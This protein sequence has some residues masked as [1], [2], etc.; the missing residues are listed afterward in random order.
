MN[1]IL[2]TLYE[3]LNREQRRKKILI[4]N[5]TKEKIKN[6]GIEKYFAL[7]ICANE[8][9]YNKV[10]YNLKNE[11]SHKYFD[12]ITIFN[13][14]EYKEFINNMKFDLSIMNPP[15]GNPKQ[16]IPAYIHN[17]IYNTISNK[18][19]T[20]CIMPCNKFQT[21]HEKNED[22]KTTQNNTKQFIL[23]PAEKANELMSIGTP[24][25]L[26]IYVSFG[27]L[28]VNWDLLEYKGNLKAKN[29]LEKIF[30]KNNISIKQYIKT[31]K[32]TDH[33]CKISEN[34]GHTG[35]EDELELVSPDFEKYIYNGK[36]GSQSFNVYLDSKTE[37]K[38]FFLSLQTK[39]MRFIRKYERD[40]IHIY[41]DYFP[42][43]N[44]YNIT[45]DDKQF[46]NYFGITGYIND[47]NAIP[48]SEWETVLEIIG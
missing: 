44:N 21:I 1:N 34:H 33:Y 35:K 23:V 10:T 12:K 13:S 5:F 46:C 27:E 9:E 38:N 15:Y 30:S 36:S 7:A 2:K 29:I 47:N 17:Q 25:D 6:A 40:G 11:P 48:N 3:L 43:M 22:L 24:N 20:I 8:A 42:W 45:W 16:S 19:N 39:L 28:S 18:C 14:I 41:F 37:C 32:I 4:I 26:G 31:Q